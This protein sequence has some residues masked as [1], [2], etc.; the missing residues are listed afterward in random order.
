MSRLFL[1]R[2]GRAAWAEPGERDFDRPLTDDGRRES[3]RVGAMMLANGYRPD[4][5]VCSP[6]R[7]ALETWHGV[8]RALDMRASEAMLCQTLYSDDAGAY[9]TVVRSNGAG[10]SLLIIGH[11]P[12]LED[13]AIGLSAPG[14]GPARADL[15]KG[16]PTAGLAVLSFEGDLSGA[17]LG[18]ATLE[19]FVI[20]SE[21]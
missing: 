12:T 16:F 21:H 8:A 3:L 15:D 1:L 18:T 17:M 6:A 14:L 7:R 2:H 9:L 11:N 10:G 5:V 19:A 20:P 4:R 13:L